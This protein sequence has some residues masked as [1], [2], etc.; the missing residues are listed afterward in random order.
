MNTPLLGGKQVAIIGG[1][2]VGLTLA[3][4]LQQR[5]AAVTVYERDPSPEQVRT[6]GGTLDIHAEDGQ[7]ALAAAGVM[8][9][10]RQLARPTGERMADQH[11]TISDDE[12][13]D[14][15]D[16]PEIDRLDL[17]RLLLESLVPGTVVWNQHFQALEAQGERFV[18][19]FA[20]Q[21]DRVADL[22]VGANGTRS[23]VRAY[24]TGTD[25]EFTGT[26]AIQG[27]IAEP[28]AR[29]PSF[30]ALVNGGNLMARGEGK[31]LF[32]H[33]KADGGLH[34][35]LSFRQPADWFAQQGLLPEPAAVAHFLAAELARWAPVYHEGFGA[36]TAFHF[37]SIY[38]V[39]LRAGRVV[40]RPITLVGDAAHA[41]SPFAG[42]GVN[43]GLVDAL[44]LADNLTNGQ[45]E[46]LEAAI[47]AYE[48][49][50]YGYANEAQQ[51]SAAAELFIHSEMSAKEMMAATRG[52]QAQ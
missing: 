1:G 29:C 34:Y 39:P 32:V 12:A 19:H 20:G 50:M 38:R 40:T 46:T 9:R 49:T 43:I 30:A 22:V 36:T 17:H 51:E 7:R 48:H 5:G 24:V 45:F 37:L 4:I 28:D 42:I 23:A 15:Y 18:L 3:S 35:Y 11:G 47:N 26:V 52:P 16:R 2:P 6:S 31:M 13:P 25:P 33:T 41:M 14:G 21:P 8:D 44:H 10:F 27:S